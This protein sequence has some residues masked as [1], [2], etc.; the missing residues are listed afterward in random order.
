MVWLV[1]ALLFLTVAIA[2]LAS[3]VTLVRDIMQAR[4]AGDLTDDVLGR[5]HALLACITTLTSFTQ[6]ASK[7]ITNIRDC[8]PATS[9]IIDFRV[10]SLYRS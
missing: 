1:A 6:P 4:S 3:L 8:S 9:Q 10:N 7:A 5:L 2:L